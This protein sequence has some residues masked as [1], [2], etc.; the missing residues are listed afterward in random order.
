VILERLMRSSGRRWL[1]KGFW[2]LTDQALFALSNF[3]LNIM[4]ARWLTAAEYGAWSL[5]FS[6]LLLVGAFH[7]ALFAEP[8]LVFGPSRYRHCTR[9]YIAALVRGHWVA[10]V[11]IGGAFAGLG[12]LAIFTGRPELGSTTIAFALAG[13]CVLFQW[14]TRRACYTQL[15]PDLAA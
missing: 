2:A 13:P 10:M 1:G 12:F 15:R 9:A 8:M 7:T 4:L 3:G 6:A 5:A 14:L 11:P